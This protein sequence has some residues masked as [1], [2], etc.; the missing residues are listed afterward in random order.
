MLSVQVPVEGDLHRRLISGVKDR[1]DFSKKK[2][3]NF[4]RQWDRADDS[5]K[6]YIPTKEIDRLRQAKKE[7]EGI[8][9]YVTLEVPYTYAV[10]MTMHTYM[11]SSMLGRSPMYQFTARHGAGQDAVMAVEAVMDYQQKSGYHLP[12]L[13]NWLYDLCRYAF[14]VVGMYW[15]VEQIVSSKIVNQKP[16]IGGFEVPWGTARPTT[17]TEI[18][19]GFEGNRLFNVR[20]HDF[21]PDPRVPLWRFQDGEFV[22]RKTTESY[23]DII[24]TEHM[25]PKYYTNLDKLPAL[26]SKGGKGW[27]GDTGSPRIELP[28][29]PGEG[30]RVP[31]PGFFNIDDAYIKLIP[32][33]WG[34]SDSNRVEIW[35][36]QVAEEEVVISAKPLGAYHN[37]F[38]YAVMEG[39]FGSEE[40]AKIGTV[41]LIR[42][43]TDILSWLINSHFYNVRKVLNNQLVF[44]P[45]RVVVKDLTKSGQRL[46][47]LKPGAYGSDVRMAVHQLQMVDV[48]QNNLRDAN[49]VEQMIQ[50]TSAVVDNVMGLQQQGGRRSATESRSMTN[51]ATN[52]LETPIRYNC[53]LGLD[54]LCQ[55]M[56]SNTQQYMSQGR[57]FAVAGNTLQT[58]GTFLMADAQTIAGQYDFVAVDG[59]AP[60]DRIAQANL[61]KE[62]MG[63]MA[64]VPEVAMQW[65]IGGMLAHTMKLAGERNIDRFRLPPQVSVAPPG[66]DLT[67]QA[68]A[69]NVVPLQGGGS[70]GVG[71]GPRG[72]P[73]PAGTG[74]SGGTI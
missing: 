32:K 25:M 33:L 22:I 18:L 67:Q 62:L 13:Y 70:G 65:D 43:M 45:S 61:W 31:G 19:Q 66:T 59:T 34:L 58:A 29:A 10:V 11:T 73:A 71:R 6:A 57:K 72:R 9:D 14:G 39:N 5:M 64:R 41:E 28:F 30:G 68:Q 8:V 2:M 50:R 42:P 56:L 52:R 63:Q 44:D 1:K 53:A 37:K 35:C 20:P 15:D 4:K 55:M 46:I 54:P 60:I 12:P 21:F 48:T 51:F 23:H 69:G 17:V 38:P 16:T 7:Y 26:Q 47:R 49:I 3:E 27:Y 24:N 74:S 36:F 40:F